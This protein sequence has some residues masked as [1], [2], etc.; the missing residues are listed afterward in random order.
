MKVVKSRGNGEMTWEWE[1]DGLWIVKTGFP[2]GNDV[3][4]EV[5]E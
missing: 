1:G 2:G 4:V 5:R 3:L